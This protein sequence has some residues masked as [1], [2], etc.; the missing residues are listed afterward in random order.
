MSAQRH[1]EAVFRPPP[2]RSPL[3]RDPRN[4]R[5]ARRGRTA[6]RP[7]WAGHPRSSG[8][9]RDPGSSGSPIRW[10]QRCSSRW[11]SSYFPLVP[12]RSPGRRI[13]GGFKV[14]GKLLG[15]D[16]RRT[17]GHGG[18]RQGPL[19]LQAL[20]VE[21]AGDPGV[22]ELRLAEQLDSLGAPPAA[23]DSGGRLGQ[24]SQS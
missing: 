10:G 18:P 23:L 22:A 21:D 17:D 11:F 13:S 19:R 24:G 14:Q 15:R 5:A 12:T 7:A 20:L 3:V 1:I 4:P 9:P 8:E 6:R 16:Q 2:G